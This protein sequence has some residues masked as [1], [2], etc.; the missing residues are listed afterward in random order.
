MTDFILSL[1]AMGIGVREA[2]AVSHS[3]FDWI[4]FY[5]EED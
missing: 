3:R 1:T 4:I 5:F 2:I